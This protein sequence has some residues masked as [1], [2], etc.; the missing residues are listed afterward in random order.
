M[1][2]DPIVQQLVDARRRSGRSQRD[3]A[4][5]AGISQNTLSEIESGKYLPRL[6]TLRRWAAVLDLEPV[7]LDK[8]KP[9][10]EVD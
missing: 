5:F 2:L 9:A 7:L 6:A 10:G 3:V 1:S 4:A 8:P